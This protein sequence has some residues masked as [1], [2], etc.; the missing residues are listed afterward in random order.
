V[1]NDSTATLMGGARLADGTLVLVG[2]AGTVLASHDGGRTFAL[3]SSA[4]SAR[5]YSAALAQADGEA[6]VLGDH[7]ARPM[8]LAAAQGG[9]AR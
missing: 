7:G 5:V 9:A 1:A 2:N 8:K 6:L 4:E 3:A